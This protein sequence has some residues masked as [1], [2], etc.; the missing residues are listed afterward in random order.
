MKICQNCAVRFEGKNTWKF[1][2]SC[3]CNRCNIRL[4]VDSFKRCI[5]CYNSNKKYKDKKVQKVLKNLGSCPA[6]TKEKGICGK[7]CIDGKMFCGIHNNQEKNL[8]QKEEKI[9]KLDE[10]GFIICR[11]NGCHVQIPK[12]KEDEKKTPRTCAKHRGADKP[13][14]RG[15]KKNGKKCNFKASDN[16]YCGNHQRQYLEEVANNQGFKYCK[17]L[18]RGCKN[19]LPLNSKKKT[20]EECLAKDREK[21][22]IKRNEEKKKKELTDNINS[23]YCKRCKTCLPKEKFKHIKLKEKTTKECIDCRTKFKDTRG[24]RPE[25]KLSL[26]Q[27]WSGLVRKANKRGIIVNQNLKEEISLLFMENCFYCNYFSSKGYL[28]GVDRLDSKNGYIKNN[29]VSCCSYCNLMKG[30]LDP[31]TFVKRCEH[32][33]KYL[34]TSDECKFYKD[35]WSDHFNQKYHQYKY[36]ATT[37]RKKKN[38]EQIP[39]KI[40]KERFNILINQDCS[41]CGKESTETHKNGIDQIVPGLGYIEG[42]IQSCCGECNFMKNKIPFD[43]YKYKCL[44]IYEN[45]K[46]ISNNLSLHTQKKRIPSLGH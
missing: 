44:N 32:I 25:R 28:N 8:K 21:D 23:H 17:N 14:C 26:V 10:K 1:C 18:E 41:I 5:N 43:K 35:L 27:A 3:S 12:N 46:Y 45:T 42:N 20:C 6:I 22:K 11:V 9:K 4:K 34:G 40:T 19:K 2:P 7:A 13:R 15:K 33:S 24:S 29:C 38:K 16:G 39:F 30:C 31:E 37:K 36:R